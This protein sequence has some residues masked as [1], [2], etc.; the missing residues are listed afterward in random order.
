MSRRLPLAPVKQRA[1]DDVPLTL[2][3]PDGHSEVHYYRPGAAEYLTTRYC[4]QA[5]DEGR[6]ALL[7][8]E[9]T[10]SGV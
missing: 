1:T 8:T 3:W 4:Q 7:I 10:P 9:T 5:V 6:T 2:A